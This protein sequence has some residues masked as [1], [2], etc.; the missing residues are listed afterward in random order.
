MQRTAVFAQC[1]FKNCFLKF[2]LFEIAHKLTTKVA[3]LKPNTEK[4]NES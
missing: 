3:K 1:G 2:C 4:S